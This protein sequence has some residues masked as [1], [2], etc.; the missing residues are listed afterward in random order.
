MEAIVL[1][2]GL[3]TRL[4]ARLP[5]VPKPMALVAGRPFLEVLLFQLRRAART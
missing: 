1:A 5:G 4:A 2:G 3:G